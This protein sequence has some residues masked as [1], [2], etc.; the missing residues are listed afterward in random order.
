[1]KVLHARAAAEHNKLKEEKTDRGAKG[2][3]TS[4]FRGELK[5]TSIKRPAATIESD[6]PT[7]KVPRKDI[8]ERKTEEG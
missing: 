3:V 1:M 8:H 4:S 6:K 7:S 5:V 2:A